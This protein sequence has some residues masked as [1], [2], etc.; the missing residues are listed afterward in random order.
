M[1]CAVTI[2]SSADSLSLNIYMVC[3]RMCMLSIC[4]C[5]CL[6]LLAVEDLFVNS[7]ER[8]SAEDIIVRVH[9]PPEDGRIKRAKTCSGFLCL[10]T[11]F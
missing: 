8:K 3:G 7:N 1:L 4:V 9:G 5:V 11:S 10:Q 2:M 6:V